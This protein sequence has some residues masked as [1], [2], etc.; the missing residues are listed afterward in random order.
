SSG[1][2]VWRV[3]ESGSQGG[4]RNAAPL[5]AN[6]VIYVGTTSGTVYALRA[7]DGSHLWQYKAPNPVTSMPAL[8]DGALYFGDDSGKLYAL[9]ASDGA[10]AWAV[11]LDNSIN[12]SPAIGM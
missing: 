6:G 5:V 9:H 2:V 11:S 12:A 4:Y 1:A 3:V 10:L 7:S 8:L